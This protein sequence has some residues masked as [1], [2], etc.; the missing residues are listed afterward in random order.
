M[1]K[2]AIIS[3]FMLVLTACVPTLIAG[4]AGATA[5]GINERRTSGAIVEDNAIPVKVQNVLGQLPDRQAAH[6]SILSYN[7]NVLITGEVPTRQFGLYVEDVV[8]KTDHVKEIYNELIISEPASIGSRSADTMLTTKVKTALTTGI[9][10]EGFNS[11]HVKVK[12]SNRRVYLMGIVNPQEAQV[13]ID[14]VRKVA[15]VDEV[16]P[17]FEIVR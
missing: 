3:T 16:V 11:A 1:R 10:L 12:S 5:L 6:V 9:K 14:I 13:A 8:R 17:L 15:G 4:G 7:Q 2:L